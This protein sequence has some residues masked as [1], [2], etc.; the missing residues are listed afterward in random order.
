MSSLNL[1]LAELLHRL[2]GLK[3][4]RLFF[5]GNP[6]KYSAIFINI[7]K[8]HGP[9]WA[10]VLANVH[11][12]CLLVQCHNVLRFKGQFEDVQLGEFVAIAKPMAMRRYSVS[13]SPLAPGADP[14]VVTAT[15]GQVKFTTGT[16]RPAVQKCGLLTVPNL[17]RYI[18]VI[19]NIHQYPNN[20]NS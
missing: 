12:K 16:G 9:S 1:S 19:Y 5:S 17:Y 18:Y 3:L 20:Y 11:G 8:E 10:Y 2:R 6:W 7:Y 14:N 15:V 13:S 4:V